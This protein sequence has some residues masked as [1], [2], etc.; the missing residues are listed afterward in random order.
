MKRLK[1]KKKLTNYVA[2]FDKKDLTTNKIYKKLSS[3]EKKKIDLLFETFELCLTQYNQN[4]D[5]KGPLNQLF[6]YLYNQ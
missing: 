3:K 4:Q 5:K 1:A 6:V 2:T